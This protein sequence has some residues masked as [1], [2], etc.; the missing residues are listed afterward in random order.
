MKDQVGL[1]IQYYNYYNQLVNPEIA[2]CVASSYFS[3]PKEL[4]STIKGLLIYIQ[5][6]DN[7]YFRW[8]LVRY[9]NPVN[10]NLAKIRNVDK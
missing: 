9:V 7:G 1:S 4:R 10:K 2:P 6:K 3:L 8:G 5:N